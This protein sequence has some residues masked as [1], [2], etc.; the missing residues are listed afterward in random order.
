MKVNEMYVQFKFIRNINLN[1]LLF[2]FVGLQLDLVIV[3][4]NYY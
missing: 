3:V 2:Y 1:I 4:L